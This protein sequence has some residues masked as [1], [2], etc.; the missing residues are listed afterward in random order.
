MNHARACRGFVVAAALV[1]LGY[2]PARLVTG[3]SVAA[4]NAVTAIS[5]VTAS[6]IGADLNHDG[7]ADDS[8][9][10]AWNIGDV[11]ALIDGVV[12]VKAGGISGTLNVPAAFLFQE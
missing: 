1:G 5:G 9:G 3:T 11:H 6:M 7:V 4:T 12:I 10:A 8:T 2:F